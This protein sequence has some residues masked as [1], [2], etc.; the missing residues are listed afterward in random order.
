M[1]LYKWQREDKQNT[2]NDDDKL[3]LS[4]LFVMKF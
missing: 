1:S 3:M 4:A 2:N